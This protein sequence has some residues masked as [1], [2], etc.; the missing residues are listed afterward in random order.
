MY[1]G[2]TLVGAGGLEAGTEATV[3]KR[4]ARAQGAMFEAKSLVQD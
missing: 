1:L 3:T 2:D 4:V